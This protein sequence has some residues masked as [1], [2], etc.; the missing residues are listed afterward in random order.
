[1]AE[2]PQKTLNGS[3]MMR[4]EGSSLSPRTSSEF[5]APRSPSMG[6]RP[7]PS[8]SVSHRHSFSDHFRGIPPPSPRASR[9]PSISL[10]NAQAL[11]D[12]PPKAGAADPVFIGRDWH[13]IAVGELIDPSDVRF[14]EVD[15]NIEHATNVQTLQMPPIFGCSN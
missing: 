15:T 11:S 10:Q 13:T 5:Q 14:V 3:N 6:A 4:V 7:I 2:R 8:P 9:H 12:N 1:M